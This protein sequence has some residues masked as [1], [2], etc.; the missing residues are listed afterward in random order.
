MSPFYV[1]ASHEMGDHATDMSIRYVPPIGASN[2]C[3][4]FSH[5]LVEDKPFIKQRL[6]KTTYCPNVAGLFD[7]V[8]YE[9]ELV[10]DHADTEKELKEV[11]H[12]EVRKDSS[13]A[14]VLF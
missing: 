14:L 1:S 2:G 7:V 12:S 13:C 3:E 5:R 10:T 11:V 9:V 6:G 8:L 4:D